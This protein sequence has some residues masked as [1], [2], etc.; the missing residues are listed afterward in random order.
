MILM[1]ME[2]HAVV[3]RCGDHVE[4]ELIPEKYLQNNGCILS[5][6]LEKCH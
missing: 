3:A 6:S 1:Y 4:L 2:A 5:I